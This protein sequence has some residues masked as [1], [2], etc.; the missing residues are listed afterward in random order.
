[1]ISIFRNGP[2]LIV[3]E[4]TDIKGLVNCIADNVDLVETDI[5]SALELA[6]Q[7][8]TI[9]FITRPGLKK[10]NA[11]DIITTLFIPVPSD[12]LFSLVINLNIYE[13]INHVRISPGFIIMRT[14]D[15]TDRIIESVTQAFKGEVMSLTDCLNKGT[16]RQ[17]FIGFTHKPINRRLSLKEDADDR[18]VLVDMNV[19]RLRRVMQRQVLRLFNKGFEKNNW[20]DVEIRIYDRYSKYMLHLERLLLVLNSLDIGLV[21]GES[22]SKDYPRFMMSVP[23]YQIRLFSLMDPVQIKKILMGMEYLD[24]GT[25]I[26]DLD[27]FFENKKVNW[28]SVLGKNRSVKSRNEFGRLQ[29][30]KLLEELTEEEKE[31]LFKMEKEIIESRD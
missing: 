30:G 7:D 4:S 17:A 8:N 5:N 26:I 23:V 11:K 20:N 27:L 28:L 18:Y 12:D 1:M 15:N 3:F 2:K 13:Y 9:I 24:D 29:R 6:D 22:W 14:V 16:S 21:L 10:I 25:R 19:H 31:I